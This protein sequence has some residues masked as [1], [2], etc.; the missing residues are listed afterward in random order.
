M[1]IAKSLMVVI[2]LANEMEQL[3]SSSDTGGQNSTTYVCVYVCM[4]V[5]IYHIYIYI[6]YVYSM[7]TYY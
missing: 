5:C 4:Y 2:N 6:K 7:C 3:N 1:L